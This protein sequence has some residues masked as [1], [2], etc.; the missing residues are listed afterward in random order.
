MTMKYNQHNK[1]QN[2]QNE[3]SLQ[4]KYIKVLDEENERI[5][6]LKKELSDRQAHYNEIKLN[7]WRKYF[8]SRK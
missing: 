4:T 3:H 2:E 6:S 1:V 8:S 5:I 7:T